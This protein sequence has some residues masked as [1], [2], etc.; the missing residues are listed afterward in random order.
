M[1]YALLKRRLWLW[2]NRLILSMSFL[3]AIPILISVIILYPLKNIFVKSLS[4]IPFEQWV[5]PGL[6]FLQYL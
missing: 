1:I 6:I 2:Q 5:I 4:D 3:F